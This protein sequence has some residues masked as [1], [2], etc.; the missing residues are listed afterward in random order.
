MA[1]VTNSPLAELTPTELDLL[2]D[3]DP[4]SLSDRQID[5]IV[6]YMRLGRAR[7]E[8]GIKPKRTEGEGVKIDLVA[9]GLKKATPPVLRRV[10]K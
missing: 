3:A 6:H 7:S 8:A 10:P 2:M 5:Q 4:L 1:Q 9:L